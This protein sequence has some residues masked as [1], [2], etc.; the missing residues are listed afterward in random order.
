LS[1]SEKW[2]TSAKD[3]VGG[4]RIPVKRHKAHIISTCVQQTL[5]NGSKEFLPT[6]SLSDRYVVVGDP[7]ALNAQ[8]ELTG[9]VHIFALPTAP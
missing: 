4:D 3:L 2:L 1:Q 8:G 6:V 7:K 5:S 9:A